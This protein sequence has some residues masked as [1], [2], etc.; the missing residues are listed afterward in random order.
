L[1][2]LDLALQRDDVSPGRVVEVF[3]K[4]MESEGAKVTR[5]M[6]EQNLTVKQTDPIFT[7]DMTPL[8]AYGQP[9]DFESAFNRV[10]NE[11]IALL[12]GDPWKSH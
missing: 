12:P 1:F 7:A 10:W 11:L 4:Y 2:D 6:F 9:W 8:L 3:A 5:A